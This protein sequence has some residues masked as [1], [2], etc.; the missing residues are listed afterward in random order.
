VAATLARK[1]G[2]E[3]YRRR[4]VLRLNLYWY[5]MR[6]L[7]CLIPVQRDQTAH[8]STNS[9]HCPPSKPFYSLVPLL[10]LW[11]IP[12]MGSAGEFLGIPSYRN[13]RLCNPSLLILPAIPIIPIRVSITTHRRNNISSFAFVSI[14]F[15]TWIFV[16]VVEI[17]T[18]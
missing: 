3:G 14:P 8:D 6:V 12:S 18:T 10:Q 1:L 11:N 17:K 9:Q 4:V 7:S 16:A 2:N 15:W 13:I 5:G